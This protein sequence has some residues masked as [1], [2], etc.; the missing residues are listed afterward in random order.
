MEQ[1]ARPTSGTSPY[2]ESWRDYRRRVRFFFGNWLGGF[3]FIAVMMFL[4]TTLVNALDIPALRQAV[5]V[6]FFVLG[7]AWLGTFVVTSIRLGRWRCPRCS[8][9][10]FSSALVS[11]PLA[12]RCLHCG[13]P[14]WAEDSSS[15]R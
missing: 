1:P 4:V 11:N 9:P 5:P 2:A 15:Q 8:K 6:L 14:K 13:L 7:F 12:R 3:V 10:F